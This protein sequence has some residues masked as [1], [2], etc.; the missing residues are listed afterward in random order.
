MP[1]RSN[2]AVSKFAY[3]RAVPSALLP[4]GATFQQLN[5]KSAPISSR[6]VAPGIGAFGS[7]IGSSGSGPLKMQSALAVV[8]HRTSTTTV[9]VFIG[10]QCVRAIFFETA[11]LYIV[12]T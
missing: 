11:R 1:E 7:E 4:R 9:R 12:D 2:G 8:A 10:S 5:A 6:F 3:A